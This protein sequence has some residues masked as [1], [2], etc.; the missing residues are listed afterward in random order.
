M[1][2]S[3]PPAWRVLIVSQHPV[4]GEGLARLLVRRS[5]APLE[6]LGRVDNLDAA[7]AALDTQQPDLV[8]V[9]CDDAAINREAFLARFVAGQRPVRVVLMS[10]NEKGPVVLYDRRTLAASQGEDWL[11]AVLPGAGGRPDPR[12]TPSGGEPV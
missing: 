6:L 4:F 5:A 8:I 1:V 7:L 2:S 3:T 10:L 9:D 11:S 12:P